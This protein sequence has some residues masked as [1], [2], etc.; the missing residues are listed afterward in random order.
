LQ[1]KAVSLV[2]DLITAQEVT[3]LN[4]VKV[5]KQHVG[6]LMGYQGTSLAFFLEL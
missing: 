5:T 3:G 4:P 1:N 6:V 2:N